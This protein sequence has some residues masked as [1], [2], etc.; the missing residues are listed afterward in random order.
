MWIS[1][2]LMIRVAE[3]C[4]RVHSAALV[5]YRSGVMRGMSLLKQ[6]K[7]KSQEEA[8]VNIMWR[9]HHHALNMATTSLATEYGG[10][11]TSRVLTWFLVARK[12]AGVPASSARQLHNHILV[13]FR[14]RS[15]PFATNTWEGRRLL[16]VPPSRRESRGPSCALTYGTDSWS[17]CTFLSLS[18]DDFYGYRTK[19]SPCRVCGCSPFG[20]TAF[21]QS[22]ILV[23]AS[24]TPTAI[25]V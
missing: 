9:C 1:P 19:V 14:W 18:H 2:K 4:S 7:Q 24:Q 17:S 23:S 15:L 5:C 3:P 8:P 11:S 22:F 6:R 12:P 10:R 21:C 20:L 16:A 25:E 13:R